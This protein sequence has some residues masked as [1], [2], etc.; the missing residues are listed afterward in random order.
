M[1]I[2]KKNLEKVVQLKNNVAPTMLD[3][4]DL[5]HKKAEKRYFKILLKL[6]S[7]KSFTQQKNDA[8]CQKWHCWQSANGV[9]KQRS[10]SFPLK[11]SIIVAQ[12]KKF[13]EELHLEKKTD[14][15]SGWFNRF[16]QQH[17]SK[18]L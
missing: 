12:A 17:G 1:K 9:D 8:S 11:R 6:W 7:S 15:S 3:N 4:D 5:W 13:H 10:E 14:G 2:K 18:L 16:K